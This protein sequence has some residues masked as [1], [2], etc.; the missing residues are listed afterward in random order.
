M[1]FIELEVRTVSII[2][3]YDVDNIEIVEDVEDEPFV[4]KL[5]SI[6]RIQSVSEEYIL[7]TSAHSR[8]MYWEYNYSMQ[9]LA[10]KLKRA[11][12]MIT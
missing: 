10:T 3:G 8:V 2:H 12:L 7:V 1:K 11:G 5:I 6:D 4:T 9:E